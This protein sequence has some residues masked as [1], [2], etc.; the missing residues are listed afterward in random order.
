MHL[1]SGPFARVPI[2]ADRD[3]GPKEF[4][5]HFRALQHLGRGPV[6]VLIHKWS[7]AID[8]ETRPGLPHEQRPQLVPEIASRARKGCSGITSAARFTHSRSGESSGSHAGA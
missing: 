2:G 8:R 7:T 6:F 1:E 3:P 5:S 4:R